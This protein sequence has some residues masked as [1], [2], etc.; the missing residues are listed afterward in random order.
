MM[1][2]PFSFS[3]ADN[4]REQR[5]QRT[6]AAR[7]PR[8]GTQ[9]ATTMESSG[10][11]SFKNKFSLHLL[12]MVAALLPS[13]AAFSMPSPMTTS[14]TPQN[15][16]PPKGSTGPGP[17]PRD[18]LFARTPGPYT[19]LRARDQ[20]LLGFDFHLQRLLHAIAASG[21]KIDS[22][23]LRG[24][25]LDAIEGALAD[26]AAVRRREQPPQ[27]SSS[28][29]SA[30][31]VD[32]FVTVHA[33]VSSPNG[34]DG[35]AVAAHAVAMPYAVMAP[36]VIL[37]VRGE[38]RAAPDVKHSQWLWDRQ[39]LERF[40][41]GP[42]GEVAL[43]RP[44]PGGGG[45]E[46][47][48]GLV[49]NVFAVQG[50]QLRTAQDGVLPGHMRGMA[51]EAAKALGI[52]L[53]LEEPLR[54]DDIGQWEEAFLTGSGRVLVPIGRVEGTSVGLSG[55]DLPTAPG[56]LTNLLRARLLYDMDEGWEPF[57]ALRQE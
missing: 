26:A 50:G 22:K 16:P 12:L 25:V 34:L 3:F 27:G 20:A 56:P 44:L 36:P 42:G 18:F 39:E 30:L 57:E 11:P 38:G 47:L 7:P 41:M 10:P 23:E 9:A 19:C 28:S 8:V 32:A 51:I 49:T 54:L 46:I 37:E 33:A 17:S 15:P 14:L 53:A 52:P 43:T 6:P 13:T 29:N 2:N 1:L 4:N 24:P 55:M 35:L 48:E 21:G 5:K 45:R 40:R 31:P